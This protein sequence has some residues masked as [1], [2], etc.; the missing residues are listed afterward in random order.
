MEHMGEV[1]SWWRSIVNPLCCSIQVLV[2]KYDQ[3][4]GTPA[5]ILG[6]MVQF[7][8]YVQ[9]VETTNSRYRCAQKTMSPD[10]GSKIRTCTRPHRWSDRHEHNVPKWERIHGQVVVSEIFDVYK[11]IHHSYSYCWWK[12]SCTMQVSS[13]I[14]IDPPGI[15]RL[16]YSQA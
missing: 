8:E 14:P 9:M 6:K 10:V 3:D 15:Q 1:N 13:W 2:S 7:E 16:L 4:K 12:K 5:I 11:L